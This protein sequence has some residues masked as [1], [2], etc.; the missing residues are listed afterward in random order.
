MQKAESII[1]GGMFTEVMKTRWMR[2]FS[3]PKE[4]AYL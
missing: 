4:R 2:K 1:C 3:F